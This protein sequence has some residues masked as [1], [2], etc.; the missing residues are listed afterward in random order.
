[1][2]IYSNISFLILSYTEKEDE[3]QNTSMWGFNTALQGW[4]SCSW[5]AR[6]KAVMKNWHKGAGV[7]RWKFFI[8]C[9]YEYSQLGAGHRMVTVLLWA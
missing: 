5:L 7:H 4:V 1:M 3:E 8:I 6:E 2:E 9:V